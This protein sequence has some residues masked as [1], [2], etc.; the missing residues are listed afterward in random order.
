MVNLIPAINGEYLAREG[1]FVLPNLVTVSAKYP[2][3]NKVFAQRLARLL[4]CYTNRR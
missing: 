4:H 3:S 1:T 2:A